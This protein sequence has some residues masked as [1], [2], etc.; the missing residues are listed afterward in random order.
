MNINMPWL[1]PSSQL[2][3]NEITSLLISFHI[4]SDAHIVH[5]NPISQL[6]TVHVL[7]K[8]TVAQNTDNYFLKDRLIIFLNA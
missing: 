7:V 1:M 5:E 2:K 6:H 4:S 3:I 8:R